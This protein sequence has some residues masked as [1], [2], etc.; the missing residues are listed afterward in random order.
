M[1]QRAIIRCLP[2][3][4]LPIALAVRF[5]RR[6]RPVGGFLRLRV[7]GLVVLARSVSGTLAS[8][9]SDLAVPARGS[10]PGVEALEGADLTAV[11]VEVVCQP[12]ELFPSPVWLGAALTGRGMGP[13]Y[14]DLAR[15][16]AHLI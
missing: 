1:V 4:P 9:I 6:F 10:S 3:F 12:V 15:S 8:S 11:K 5:V 13:V 14:E 16:D 7:R 2:G